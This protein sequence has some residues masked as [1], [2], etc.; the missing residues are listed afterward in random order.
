MLNVLDP[1]KYDDA[2]KHKVWQEAMDEELLAIQNNNIWELIKLS[3]D[4]EAIGLKWIYKT[5]CKPI[6]EILKHKAKL[7]AKGYTQQFGVDYD[8]VFSP[9]ARLDTMRIL[10]SLATKFNWLVF[11]L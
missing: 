10:F 11:F 9:I 5:K 7:I 2:I 6:S 3:L 1:V 8:E 4:K